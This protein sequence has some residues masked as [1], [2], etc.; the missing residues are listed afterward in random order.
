MNTVFLDFA[1]L[2]PA[3]LDTANLHARLTSLK[4]WPDSQPEEILPRLAGA[5]AVVINKLRLDSATLHA[6]TGL[7]LVC[8]AATGTDNV[9]LDAA[10][11]LNIAVCN[12]R[13]YCTPSVVQ[14]VFAL[15]LALT[16]HL[17]E[18]REAIRKG[19]WQASG[20]FCLFDPP[21]RELHGKTLG[22]IGLGAL[23]SGVAGVA[24]A[25]GMRV[26]AANLP[27]R[28][29]QPPGASGQSAPRLPLNDLL[30]EAHVV[31]LHCPL[32]RETHNLI[33]A[34]T[35]QRMRDDALLI[36]T[37]R[38]GL[39]DSAALLDALNQGE[40][41]GAGIDV[42]VNEPPD[43]DDILLTSNLPNLIVTPHIAWSARESRQRALDEIVANIV[44]FTN[45]QQRNRVC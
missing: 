1:S 9:D 27:W 20:Q 7:K 26:I 34:D 15:I 25:F 36:N 22:V 44:A 32:T 29:N 43:D 12:L 35:L 2:H 24:R 45:G 8:L 4:L 41:A 42:L 16:Q 10:R 17:P 18:H 28:L 40:I 3:D 33:N 39:V 13:D 23:G 38:G 31:S 5:D 37:A 14:H 30:E 6:A 21:I 19:A 11:N